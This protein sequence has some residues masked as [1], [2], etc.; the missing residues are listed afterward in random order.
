MPKYLPTAAVVLVASCPVMA[1]TPPS[2]APTAGSPGA[3]AAAQGEGQLVIFVFEGDTPVSGAR[4]LADGSA[5]GKT[6]ADGGVVAKLSA[7]RHTLVLKRGS[8]TAFDLDV[9]ARADEQVRIIATLK[10]GEAPELDI[11]GGGD[12]PV[13]AESGTVGA[14]AGTISGRVTGPSGNPLSGATVRVPSRGAAVKTAD[15]G[16]FEIEVPPGRYNLRVT[17]PNYTSGSAAGLQVDANGQATANISLADSGIKLADYTVTADYVEGSIASEIELQRES[18]QITSVIGAEQI[19]RTGDSN[20]AEA[21]QRVSGLLI[22]NGR[23]AVIRGQPYRYTL[24]TFNGLP[25]PSP[26]PI[27]E[28][29]PLNLFSDTILANIQVQKSYS[30]DKPGNFGGGLV[31]L[32]TIS[33][34]DE[35]FATFKISTGANTLSTGE[36]GLTYKGSNED[37]LGQDGGEREL[38]GGLPSQQQ[39]S[40]L[41]VEDRQ[42]AGQSFDDIYIVE[43][44][45]LPP[46]I[47]LEAAGGRSFETDYGTFG[48]IASGTYAQQ[49]RRALERDNVY[50]ISQ[51]DPRV[52]F[53]ERRTDRQVN[54]SGFLA[55]SGEW[56]KH[57]VLSNTLFV[58]NSQDRTEISEG[59]DLTSDGR[60]ERRFLLEFQRRDLFLTQLMGEHDFDYFQ[61]DWRGQHAETERDRPDRSTYRYQRPFGTD[62]GLTFFADTGLQRDFN[63]VNSDLNSANGDITIP[64][65]EIGALDWSLKGGGDI[66]VGERISDTRRFQ[67][68]PG[69]GIRLDRAVVEQVVNDNRINLDGSGV[70]FS[71]VTLSSDSYTADTDTRGYYVGGHLG[72]GD[73]IETDFGIRNT[74]ANYEVLTGS[75][76]TGG[77]DES[78]W[79]PSINVTGS[80]TDSFQIRASYGQTVS[81][82]RLVELAQT[83]F[84]NPDTGEQFIGNPS[85]APTEIDSYDLRF[86]FYPSSTENLNLGLFYKELENSIEQQFLPLASGTSLTSFT[87]GQSGE[88]LGLETGGRVSFDRVVAAGW[89][90]F[91][92]VANT[93]FQANFAITTSSVELDP[94]SSGAAT[95]Q[96]RPLT[97][98]AD[99]TLNLQLGY[100]G[101]TQDFTLLYNRVGERL[102]QAGTQGLPDIY[103]QP[104]AF[105]GFTYSLDLPTRLPFVG[106][107]PSLS[108]AQVKFKGANLL[109]AEREFR[110]G[111][112][113]Q[114]RVQF[115][116]SFSA[117]LRLNLF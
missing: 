115:G 94:Q 107:I 92:W 54:L 60:E 45:Q 95:N 7:G 112:R 97:G 9:I 100:D 89:I 117:S 6:G 4:L 77:F 56:D 21:L 31:G 17:H 79:L 105:L 1:Q 73:W 16:R 108:G 20:A 28:A 69:N 59:F 93:Y 55:L 104:I 65:P 46:D 78:F 58:R 26:D 2:A 101:Q 23:Y 96:R 15:D 34:P 50:T 85:L 44:K 102:D 5:I 35:P 87:N 38:P 68:I 41:P 3:E 19:S 51:E 14:D 13:L 32:N 72:F 39:L 11:R 27:I 110:Q 18:D 71:E 67:F 75:D 52:S 76:I 88:I 86:E 53:L 99:T 114:R 106:P 36:L 82:P 81:Y 57:K 90:P 10:N 66:S 12:G 61:L 98:Q 74:Q 63:E 109:D 37:A 80:V 40:R 116:R 29:V 42:R 8:D 91:D 49:W 111:E 25:L 103:Q 22:E 48:A 64:L 30:A 43:E 70:Q 47:G 83:T 84:F 62:Q 113:L 24:T 33:T